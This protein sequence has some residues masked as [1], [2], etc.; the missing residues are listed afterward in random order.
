MVFMSTILSKCKAKYVIPAPKKD[1]RKNW[2]AYLI[3]TGWK[4]RKN[5]SEHMDKLL[6]GK[7]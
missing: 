2:R 7:D 6:Y 4:R 5:V 1:K 3:P